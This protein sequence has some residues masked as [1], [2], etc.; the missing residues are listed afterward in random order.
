MITSR[1][2]ALLTSVIKRYVK[3]AEPVSSKFLEKSGFFSLSSATIRAEMNE[4]E[5]LGYLAHL[6]TSGGRMPT[7]RAY[8]YFVDN[9]LEEDACEPAVEEKRKIKSELAK[10]SG[11]PHEVNKAIAQLLSNLSENLVIANVIENEDFYKIGLSSLFELPEFRA[12]DKAF[13]L[14]SFFDGFEN[15]FD[16]LVK[17][18]LGDVTRF[19][20]PMED[21]VKV[22][23][24]RENPVKDIRDETVMFAKYNL[25][26][27]FTGA[28]TL[29][30]PTRMNYARNIG[31]V[32]F[33]A[34]ELNKLARNT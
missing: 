6:H 31:L 30:G 34:K 24:G 14:T 7:D 25:P 9:L 10:A 11:S 3:S 33:T 26:H 29:V 27:N 19:H 16:H 20:Q 28:L 18:F 12:F 32:K 15:L 17:E 2:E 21:E 23:I 5:S 13:R 4:L 22:F 1:Q 8:R